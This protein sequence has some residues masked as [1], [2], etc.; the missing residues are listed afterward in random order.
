MT[1]H[2]SLGLLPLLIDCL[3][4]F[5]LRHGSARLS[6]ARFDLAQLAALL[7]CSSVLVGPFH[8]PLLLLPS[9]VSLLSKA[10]PSGN[11]IRSTTSYLFR[12]QHFAFARTGSNVILTSFNIFLI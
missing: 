2:R 3:A 10:L 11:K 5:R 12:L 8:Y 6:T 1:E 7:C 9:S 4:R